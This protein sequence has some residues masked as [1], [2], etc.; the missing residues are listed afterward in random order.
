MALNMNCCDCGVDTNAIG[1]WYMV[2]DQVWREAWPGQQ[3]QRSS[4]GSQILC[5]G[6]L[7]Q[8]IGRTLGSDDFT[9]VPINVIDS[10]SERLADRLRKK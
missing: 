9:A 10:Q 3:I 8:R 1:E 6:C 7:E 4:P 2:L 5:I